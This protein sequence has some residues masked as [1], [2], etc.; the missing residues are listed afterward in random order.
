MSFSSAKKSP[1]ES[2]ACVLTLIKNLPKK[3]LVG[4]RI[5]KSSD[6]LIAIYYMVELMLGLFCMTD[7]LYIL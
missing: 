6:I 3:S 4:N 1:V 2:K 7:R 5:I